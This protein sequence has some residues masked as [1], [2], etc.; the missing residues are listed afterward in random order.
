M[1][2]AQRTPMALEHL[3]VAVAGLFRAYDCSTFDGI[4]CRAFIANT[5]T[6]LI[7]H[8]VAIDRAP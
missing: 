5:I 6:N 3:R 1:Q 2:T 4:W 7:V 8:I